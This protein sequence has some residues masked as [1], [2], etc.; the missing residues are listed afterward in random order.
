MNQQE[1]QQQRERMA[2]I[3][4]QLLDWSRWH[5][6]LC[7]ENPCYAKAGALAFLAHCIGMDMQELP[8]FILKLDDY[9]R[10][11]VKNNDGECDH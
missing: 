7:Q 4:D 10:N 3:R 2:E 5:Q 6:L 9:N 8:Q 1:L 11:C